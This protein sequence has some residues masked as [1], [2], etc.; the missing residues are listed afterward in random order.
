MR[1]LPQSLTALLVLGL[2]ACNSGSGTSRG[3]GSSANQCTAVNASAEPGPLAADG[4]PLTIPALREWQPA[5]GIFTLCRESRVVVT[6]A[7]LQ[8]V[9]DV[10]AEDLRMLSGQAIPVVGGSSAS[11]RPGDVVVNFGDSDTRLGREGYRMTV[12]GKIVI[13]AHED[14]GAFYGTRSVLQLLN[15]STVIRAGEALDWP[16]YPERGLMVDFGRKYYTP[17]WFKRHVR[18]IAYLKY[19]LLHLHFSET[20]GF[21]IESERHPEIVAEDH[22]TKAEVREII[23]LAR[24][25]FITVVP[26]I[27]MPSHMGAALAPHPEFQLV[28]ITGQSNPAALDVTNPAAVQF[29]FELIDEYLPLFPGP[30]W[31][32]GA[33]EYIALYDYLRYPQLASY[34]QQQYGSGANGK[35]AVHGFTNQVNARV[36]SHGKTLRMWNDDTGN[37]AAVTLDPDIVIEWWTNFSPLGDLIL[38]PSAQSLIDAGHRVLNGSWWPT[39]YVVGSPAYLP[40]PVDL[41]PDPDMASAYER[42]RLNEFSGPLYVPIPGEPRFPPET[43]AANNAA[44]LGATLHVWGDTPDAETEDEVAE[45]ISPRLRVIAQ[46]AWE[47]PQLTGSYSAFLPMMDAVGHAPGYETMP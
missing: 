25:Y 28:D 11:A 46:K 39:Y 43:I 21:R 32:T 20:L 29:A 19:N 26:E 18:E 47:S 41:P 5:T 15:Q 22:L 44:N 27:G 1:I 37:G 45:N 12:G 2:A 7:R 42:W 4:R 36:R 17:A 14:A 9:G 23:A 6:D 30:Y 8:S 33:D 10:F 24:R 31:H 35:D 34:A 16:R 40:F 13:S 3:L 38:I